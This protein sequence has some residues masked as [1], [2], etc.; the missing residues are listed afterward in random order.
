MDDVLFGPVGFAAGFASAWPTNIV[1]LR[2]RS[3]VNRV[4]FV[5]NLHPQTLPAYVKVE[6]SRTVRF[7]QNSHGM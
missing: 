3:V 5:W 7:G 1:L 6:R 2:T 4:G